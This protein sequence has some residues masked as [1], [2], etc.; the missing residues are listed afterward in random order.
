M[1]CAQ[2]TV[3]KSVAQPISVH[4]CSLMAQARPM[5]SLQAAFDGPKGAYS[6]GPMIQV[7]VQGWAELCKR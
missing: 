4:K 2:R 3:A 6:S 1:L 5:P 7:H